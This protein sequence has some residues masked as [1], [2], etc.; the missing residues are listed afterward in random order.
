MIFGE[1]ISRTS[2]LLD[3]GVA[4]KVVE[5]SGA[6]YSYGGERIGQGRENAKRFLVENPEITAEIDRKLRAL[7]GM[8]GT[9]EREGA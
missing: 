6:W 1:G 4:H 9:Q 3:L 7:L 5:K 8:N 2:S